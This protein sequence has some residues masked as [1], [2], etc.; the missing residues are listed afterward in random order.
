MMYHKFPTVEENCGLQRKADLERPDAWRY[1]I[2]GEDM[3]GSWADCAGSQL[4]LEKTGSRNG[5]EYFQVHTT[6]GHYF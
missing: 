4:T 3:G 6:S 2:K 5:K 1:G